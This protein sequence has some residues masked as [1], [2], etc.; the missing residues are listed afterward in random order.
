MNKYITW[1]I[2]IVIII[3]VCYGI[4]QYGIPLYKKYT[5]KKVETVFVPT[6]QVKEGPFLVSFTE[7]GNMDAINTISVQ[8]PING[9]IISILNDGDVVKKGDVIAVLDS[10]DLKTQ[11]R[12]RSV[13]LENARREVER[14]EAE[15]TIFKEQNKTELEQAMADFDFNKTELDRA[16]KDLEKK[17][18]LLAEKLIAGTEVESAELAVKSKELTVKKDEMQLALKKKDIESKEQQK[19]ADIKNVRFRFEITKQQFDDAQFN[20]KNASIISPAAGMIVLEDM[21]TGNGRRKFQAG[22]SLNINAPVCKIPD[23]NNMRVNTKVVEGN[24]SKLKKGTPVI[25]K[26]EAIKDR[27][28][29]GKVEEISTLATE[30]QPWESGA[31]PGKKT[32]SVNVNVT[33]KDPKN[34]RPGMTVETQFVIRNLGVAT[35]LPIEAVFEREGKTWVFLKKKDTY[36]KTMVIIGESNDNNVQIR[37]GLKKG[38]IVALE[39]PAEL[40]ADNKKLSNKKKEKD[41]KTA[42]IPAGEKK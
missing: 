2:R 25:L 20:V 9:K 27:V 28:Y 17:N 41:G 14:A 5:T 37:H 1:L 38:D 8:S 3:V 4:W 32:F 35:Y 42:P 6:A 36:V 33:E 15:F 31:V 34:F 21:W 26:V 23:L 12:S 13:E 16:V 22:D 30:D 24:V 19:E 29:H 11:A 10:G 39:D 7:K 40:Q 18:R